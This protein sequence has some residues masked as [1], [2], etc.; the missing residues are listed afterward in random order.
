MA[1]LM[2]RT[3]VVTALLQFGARVM[4]S[5]PLHSTTEHATAVSSTRKVTVTWWWFHFHC[6]IGAQDRVPLTL[7]VYHHNVHKP[8]HLRMRRHDQEEI[9]RLLLLACNEAEGEFTDHVRR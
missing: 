5:I 2:G 6:K 8:P 1:A 9:M 3:E 7:F 4:D